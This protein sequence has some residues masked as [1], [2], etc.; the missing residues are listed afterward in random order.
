MLTR[1]ARASGTGVT[2][3][4]RPGG[5]ESR[6]RRQEQKG[7]LRF[8]EGIVL[9]SKGEDFHGGIVNSWIASSDFTAGAARDR[10]LAAR[11]SK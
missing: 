4:F 5:T 2:V 3:D 11:A 6:D 9:P 1:D 7:P 8:R 10:V